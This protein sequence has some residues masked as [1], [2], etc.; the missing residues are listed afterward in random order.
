MLP[1]QPSVLLTDG[2]VAVE[3]DPHAESVANGP[4]ILPANDDADISQAYG[5]HENVC[6]APASVPLPSSERRVP[7]MTQHDQLY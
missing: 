2:F 6:L 3:D 4:M 1:C 7:E 5:L